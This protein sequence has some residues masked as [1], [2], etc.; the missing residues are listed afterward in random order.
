MKKQVLFLS[1]FVAAIVA[2]M[3][4]GVS[5]QKERGPQEPENDKYERIG[6]LHNE[7]LDFVLD[8]ISDSRTKGGTGLTK[9]QALAG[10][11][12]AVD[13]FLAKKGVSAAVTKSGTYRFDDYDGAGLTAAQKEFYDE[14]IETVTDPFLDYEST[15]KV[16][17]QI[18]DRV[19]ATLP[20][21]EAEALL[22]GIVVAQYSMEYWYDNADKWKAAGDLDALAYQVATK[23]GN[24]EGDDEL[25]WKEL[26]S[27]DAGGAVAGALVGA[28]P[29]ALTGGL[30]ASAGDGVKQLID[31]IL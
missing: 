3:V 8:Y 21:Q 6:Q 31:K 1:V 19:V 23:G 2:V 15:Q 27:S 17:S 10:A 24:P 5:C 4:S 18:K 20:E 30:A 9:D 14:L 22:C 12:E 26:V 25:S 13:V 7:G 11:M 29:G 28:L 16:V